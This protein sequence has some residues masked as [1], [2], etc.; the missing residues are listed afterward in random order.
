MYRLRRGVLWFALIVSAGSAARA[1]TDYIITVP[2]TGIIEFIELPL[3]GRSGTIAVNIPSTSSGLDG[4]FGD[5]DGHTIYIEGPNWN[6]LS[7]CERL[8]L[9]VFNRSGNL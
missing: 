9:V 7:S 3:S 6:E 1:S 4:V 2:R 5:P 8:L